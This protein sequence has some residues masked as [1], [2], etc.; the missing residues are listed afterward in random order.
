MVKYVNA[1]AGAAG[2]ALTGTYPNPGLATVGIASGGTGQ[3]T[4]PLPPFLASDAGMLAWN[5][6]PGNCVSATALTAGGAV[7]LIRVNI[8]AAISVANVVI[9]V[10]TAG[11]SLTSGQNFVGLYNSSGTLIGTS[12]DQSVPWATN[13]V[14]T[15]ALSGGPFNLAAGTFV[16]VAL[17]CN[18]AGS[19][20]T[21]MRGASLNTTTANAGFTAATARSATNGTG[22]TALPGSV[23]PASNVLAALVW[24]AALS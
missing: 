17:M 16:W 15:A 8:R 24:W 18:T 7:N 3:V 6:D 9:G 1:P 2:G 20:P 21:I 12:A 14:K 22:T 5:F 19:A 4:D 10:T 23:T 11:S 13:G